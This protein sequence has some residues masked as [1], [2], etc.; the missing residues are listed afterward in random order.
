MT[1]HHGLYQFIPV[2]KGAEAHKLGLFVVISTQWNG[3]LA[4]E[5][6]RKTRP[7]M[8]SETQISGLT[9]LR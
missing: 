4:P 9:G 7:A 2:V 6:I 5:S 8:T 1:I 3:C